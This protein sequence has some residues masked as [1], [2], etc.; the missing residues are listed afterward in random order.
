MTRYEMAEGVIWQSRLKYLLQLRLGCT[1]DV[2][3]KWWC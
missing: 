1:A 3:E 2:L